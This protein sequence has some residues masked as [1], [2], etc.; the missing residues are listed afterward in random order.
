MTF[1]EVRKLTGMTRRVI[2]EYEDAGL[3]NRPTTK[4]KYGHLEYSDEDVEHLFVIRMYRELKYDKKQIREV[5]RNNCSREENLDMQIDELKRQREELDRL[6]DLAIAMRETGLSPSKLRTEIPCLGKSSFSELSQMLGFRLYIEDASVGP[7]FKD[8]ESEN[9]YLQILDKKINK[10]GHYFKKKE[11]C[12][13]DKV[14]AVITEVHNILGRYITKSIDALAVISLAIKENPYFKEIREEVDSDFGTGFVDFV[15]GSIKAYCSKNTGEEYDNK[16]YEVIKEILKLRCHKKEHKSGEVQL[17]V[18]EL[19][20]ILGIEQV[21]TRL[22]VSEYFRQ[23]MVYAKKMNYDEK[24]DSIYG[25][26]TFLYVEKS[27]EYYLSN[28]KTGGIYY[29]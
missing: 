16:I 18:L 19:F 14:Q 10:L 17:K 8:A 4:N 27:I 24:F 28:E 26:G 2:Q 9:L 29:E 12:N 5:L 7:A 25:I 23:F 13:N 6:I 1:E 20:G 22:F 15:Y 3:A 11:E 21:Y